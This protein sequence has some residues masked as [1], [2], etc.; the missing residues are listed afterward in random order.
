[1]I[2][3]NYLAQ[4]QAAITSAITDVGAVIFGSLPAI[5][6]IVAVLIGLFF[7]VRLIKRQIGGNK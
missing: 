1:M 4:A 5:L 3:P 2:A 7:I 6:G